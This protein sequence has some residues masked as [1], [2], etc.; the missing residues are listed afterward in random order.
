MELALEAG[1]WV[2]FDRY[3]LHNLHI[4]PVPD[5]KLTT[6]DPWNELGLTESLT[7]L[8]D[9]NG[10]FRPPGFALSTEGISAILDFVGKF[11]L[12]G[13]ALH[14]LVRLELAPIWEAVRP[15]MPDD[16]PDQGAELEP[17]QYSYVQS[18]G[19]RWIRRGRLLTGG[20]YDPGDDGKKS[21]QRVTPEGQLDASTLMRSLGSDQIDEDDIQAWARYFPEVPRE[22]LETYDYPL[23]TTDRFWRMYAEPAADIYHAATLL[24]QAITDIKNAS[25]PKPEKLV[26]RSYLGDR[27]VEPAGSGAISV[28]LSAITVGLDDNNKIRAM[29]E[30]LLGVA[31]WRAA[32]DLD[33]GLRIDRCEICNGIFRAKVRTR[34]YCSR[35]CRHT[36]QKR[37]QRRRKSGSQKEN[38][39]DE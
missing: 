18:A 4:R 11:G 9:T 14:R 27:G 1:K 21:G 36:G 34:R 13:L 10:P 22:V 26:S 31:A 25:G 24:S 3:E 29:S 23:P 8:G 5:A 6:Y 20:E 2:R 38:G 19:W 17:V 16:W 35:R 32:K 15:K 30:S 39:A 33:A 12:L 37:A 7:K 28:L